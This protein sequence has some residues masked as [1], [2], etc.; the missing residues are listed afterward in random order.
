[1]AGNWQTELGIIDHLAVGILNTPYASPLRCKKP[2]NPLVLG[3][4]AEI[5]S[6][7]ASINLCPL[8]HDERQKLA[9]S[10]RGTTEPFVAPIPQHCAQL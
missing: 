8:I 7:T 4:V 1:M 10:N 6:G 9:I 5:H 3:V 2:R